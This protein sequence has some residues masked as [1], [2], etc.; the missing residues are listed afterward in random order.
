M[1]K[2]V[3]FSI[4]RMLV[5]VLVIGFGIYICST[6]IY[7]SKMIEANENKIASYE[8]QLQEE[9]TKKQQLQEQ[10][11]Q[12]GSDEYIEQMA[13]DKLGLYKSNERVF[14]DGAAD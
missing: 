4:N 1:K 10:E 6:L 9:Q 14:I 3:R 5:S 8:Q 13:R 7:Q 2:K 11:Q 12:Q